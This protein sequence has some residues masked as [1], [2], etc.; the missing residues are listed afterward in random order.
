LD[1][2][3]K[4]LTI[5]TNWPKKI[6]KIHLSTLTTDISPDYMIYSNF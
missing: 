2:N 6:T 5:V 3:L 4:Y 1:L